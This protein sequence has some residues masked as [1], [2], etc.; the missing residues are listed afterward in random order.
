LDRPQINLFA[1]PGG[2]EVD[3]TLLRAK[4]VLKKMGK[5]FLPPNEW[6]N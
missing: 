1:S 5:P 2:I 4:D 3:P 6:W